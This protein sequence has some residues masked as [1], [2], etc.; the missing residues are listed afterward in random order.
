[1]FCTDIFQTRLALKPRNLKITHQ[2]NP[3]LPPTIYTDEIRL[4]QILINLLSHSF[5]FTDVGFISLDVNVTTEEDGAKY[6]SFSVTDTGKGIPEDKI[7]LLTQPCNKLEN[8]NNA[9][10]AG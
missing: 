10:G 7:P 1:E 8:E 9:N 4:K 5:K 6:L 2:I 3:E